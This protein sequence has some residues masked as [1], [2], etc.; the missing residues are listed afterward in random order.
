MPLKPGH[1]QKTISSNIREMVA[2]GHPQNQAVAASLANARRHAKMALKRAFGGKIYEPVEGHEEDAGQEA[3]APQDHDLEEVQDDYTENEGYWKGGKYWTGGE[4]GEE[5]YYES[6][7]GDDPQY[8]YNYKDNEHGDQMDLVDNK[9]ASLQER[10]SK[11]MFRDSESDRSGSY[12][13]R[14]LSH[15]DDAED[16][17]PNARH[18]FS[19]SRREYADGGEVDEQGS[20]SLKKAF[21]S[22]KDESEHYNPGESFM[23]KVKKAVA[24]G[25]EKKKM[26][27]G[28]MAGF[29]RAIKR[30]Y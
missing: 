5:D 3:T 27:H 12:V 7:G 15:A 8:G 11:N 4:V 9:Q 6:Y 30:G 21:H 19:M 14:A 25:P 17:G 16:G 18:E 20:E 10:P 2:S 1:S 29:A 24:G 28:G 13:D 26:A 23:D 22:R